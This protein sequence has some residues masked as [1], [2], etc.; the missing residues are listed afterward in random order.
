M[1]PLELQDELVEELKR[2]FSE[3]AYKVPLGNAARKPLN[4]YAQ[5]IPINQTDD[6]DDPVPYLIVRLSTGDD[7]GT[8][9]SFNIVN[10]VIIAGIWDDGLEAQ[11][12]RDILNIIQKIYE[13]F[14][15]NP[16]LNN[17]AAYTGEFHWA[18]QEDNYYPYYFGACSLSF[19][20]AAI[21]R[22]DEYA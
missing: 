18:A 14:A 19:N 16:N 2:L 17:K 20:I 22:E 21:R 4:V 8:Q 13:R 3:Y 6:E 11:G 12:H 5:H 15:K 9:S 7:D 10:L 1:T